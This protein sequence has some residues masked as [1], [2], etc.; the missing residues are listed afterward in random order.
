MDATKRAETTLDDECV[1][2]FSPGRITT[3]CCTVFTGLMCRKYESICG[4]IV[5]RATGYN[6]DSYKIYSSKAIQMKSGF[7]K[8]YQFVLATA[9]A[10]S[11]FATF[12]T[13]S[14]S[15][16]QSNDVDFGPYMAITQKTVMKNFV[17][18][19]GASGRV[20]VAFW[21]HKDG[22]ITDLRIRT[23]SGNPQL[24]QAGLD[25]V[26]KSVPFMPLPP[27]SGEKVDLSFNFN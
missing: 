27:G 6:S 24:D 26:L 14:S 25:A 19:K 18:P 17:R 10:V 23:S 11:L 1:M 22:Q 5:N 16:G 12:A 4:G 21:I 15:F 2:S 20:L 8:Q 9:F 3:S 7:K 13:F